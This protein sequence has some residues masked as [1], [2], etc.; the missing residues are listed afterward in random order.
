M[1][2][3]PLPLPP[4][5][6]SSSSSSPAS[7]LDA[8]QPQL[9]PPPTSL[10]HPQIYRILEF[11]TLHLNPHLH[12]QYELAR[13]LLLATPPTYGAGVAISNYPAQLI[14]R[15]RALNILSELH[16]TSDIEERDKFALAHL[17]A[18]MYMSGGRDIE[19]LELAKEYCLEAI[20]GRHDTFGLE[21]PD[22]QASIVLLSVLA[23]KMGQERRQG[24]ESTGIGGV[25]PR[26]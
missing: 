21:D 12:T 23:A 8:N 6:T 13:T 11:P 7:S 10:Y 14:D 1:N 20:N 22:T 25:L 5:F 24:E 26:S 2:G 9:E 3:L 15:T 19:D 18:Q 4:S 16:K 17:L